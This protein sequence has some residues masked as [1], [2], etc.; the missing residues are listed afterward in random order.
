MFI[1]LKISSPAHRSKFFT[2]IVNSETAQKSSKREGHAEK[3][4]TSVC[5]F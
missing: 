1:V 5:N 3:K 4:E 2:N